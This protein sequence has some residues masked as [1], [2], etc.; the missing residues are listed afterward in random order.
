MHTDNASVVQLKYKYETYT[1]RSQGVARTCVY[2]A[3]PGENSADHE[4]NSPLFLPSVEVNA[5]Q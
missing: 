2:R 5:S 4:S 3:K 1:F